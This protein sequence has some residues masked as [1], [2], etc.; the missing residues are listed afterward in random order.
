[1]FYNLSNLHLQNFTFF[2]LVDSYASDDDRVAQLAWLYD[3][4]HEILERL[5]PRIEDMTGLTVQGSSAEAIQLQNYGVGGQ[6][7]AHYDHDA[8]RTDEVSEDR[9]ATLMLYVK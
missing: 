8:G 7:Y 4:H 5:N 2:S 9:I 6:Y 1:M 3:G